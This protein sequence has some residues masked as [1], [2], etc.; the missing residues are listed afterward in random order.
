MR[1][2]ERHLSEFTGL[3]TWEDHTILAALLQGQAA[4]IEAVRPAFGA[5]SAASQALA[6]NL[7]RGGRLLYAGAGS[8]IRQGIVDGIELP[9]TFGFPSHRLHFLVA[10]GREALFDSRGASEDE[11]HAAMREIVG[12]NLTSADTLIA[13]AASGTTPYTIAAARAAKAAGALVVVIV[14]NAGSPL[15]SAADHEIFLDSGP[16]VIAGSTRMAAGTAQKAALNL[17]STLTHIR[18]GAVHDGLMVNVRADNEKLRERA[19]GIVMAIAKVDED[20]AKEALDV[21]GG[22][23]KLAVLFATGVQDIETARKLLDA[24]GGNLRSALG[25]F[26]KT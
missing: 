8:S 4:A 2:T 23:V 25:Q 24:S 9:A 12:L 5:I 6:G 14:N 18:L 20:Q 16:E 21:A 15:A 19:R 3:D 1:K 26:A 17:L 10:G 11:S 7:R 13:V 22:E